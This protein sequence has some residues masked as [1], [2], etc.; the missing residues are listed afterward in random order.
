MS[1]SHVY[2]V[3]AYYPNF[4]CKTGDCRHPCCTGW[5][6]AISMQEYFRMIGLD[7]SPDLRRR[8]DTAFHLPDTPSEDRY[9]IISRRWDGDCPLHLPNG[10]CGLQ[11]E[12][13]EDAIP[14]V[15][16]YYPRSPKTRYAYQCQCSNSCEAVVELLFDYQEPMTFIRQNLTFRFSESV[17]HEHDPITKLF[18]SLQR[19]CLRILQDRSHTLSRRLTHLGELIQVMDIPYRQGNID[20]V[21]AVLPFSATLGQ[22]STPEG[23][24]S[25]QDKDL[26]TVLSC[27]RDLLNWVEENN[28]S[29][30]DHAKSALDLLQ[31]SP[32]DPIG[33]ETLSLW[34]Q[35]ESQMA[36]RFPDND[37]M[38]EQVLVNYLCYDSFPLSGD[39]RTL[40]DSYLALSTT[41]L[42]LR[43]LSVCHLA[44][45]DREKSDESLTPTQ[46][47]A[48]I[49]ATLFRMVSHTNFA[50]NTAILARRFQ[51]D[52]P[53][54]AFLLCRL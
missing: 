28:V 11:C 45:Y 9:A 40:W 38:L 44:I 47:Y 17:H 34:R 12:C 22:V 51:Y 13:G 6:I 36:Q 1:F 27:A 49:V 20:G 35:F 4:R 33:E 3:P 14:S 21:H 31:M 48:D 8:L 7:C 37:R 2:S 25:L 52:K 39:H 32:D 24:S 54:T 19:A 42:L 15:C 29:L 50:H 53:Q 16:R 43:V 46:A 18:P 5:D 10:L 30:Q 41:Y 26:H 23:T